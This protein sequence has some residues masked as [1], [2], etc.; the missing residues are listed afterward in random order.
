MYNPGKQVMLGWLQRTNEM[1]SILG[2]MGILV[3]GDAKEKG[4]GGEE[5]KERKKGVFRE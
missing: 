5:D 1:S 4:Y 3:L 2:R